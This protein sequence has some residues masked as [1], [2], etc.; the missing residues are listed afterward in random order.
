MNVTDI[1]KRIVNDEDNITDNIEIIGRISSNFE[2]LSSTLYKK[3][4]NIH[5]LEV[6][7]QKK[8]GRHNSF[9]EFM[10]ENNINSNDMV[11]FNNEYGIRLSDNEMI[12]ELIYAVK[13][14]IPYKKEY[15]KSI[16]GKKIFTKSLVS[17]NYTVRKA[18][19]LE[20]KSILKLHYDNNEYD[21]FY[22]EHPLLKV[23]SLTPDFAHKLSNKISSKTAYM[24]SFNSRYHLM[25]REELLDDYL[26]KVRPQMQN[27]YMIQKIKTEN[28]EKL[29]LSRLQGN[30]RIDSYNIFTIDNKEYVYFKINAVRYY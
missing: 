9:Y 8:D 22:N 10:K 19:L 29:C 21:L 4:G 25:S 18:E 5:V 13:D 1:F 6:S 16:T 28:F 26:N 11:H 7:D 27:D 30:P 24:I 23:G 17:N 15:P 2:N 3:N 20:H 12:H 14:V